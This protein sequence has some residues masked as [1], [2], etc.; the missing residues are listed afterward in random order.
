[1]TQGTLSVDDLPVAFTV[2]SNGDQP[3]VLEP[4]LRMLASARRE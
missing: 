2:L 3:L 1:M 4:V